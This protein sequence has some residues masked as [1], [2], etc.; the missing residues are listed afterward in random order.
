MTAGLSDWTEVLKENNVWNRDSS[1]ETIREFRG[2]IV[3]PQPVVCIVGK[4]IVHVRTNDFDTHH[5]RSIVWTEPATER[6]SYVSTGE[7]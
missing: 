6:V 5:A 7:L 2:I 4:E 1:R 3:A